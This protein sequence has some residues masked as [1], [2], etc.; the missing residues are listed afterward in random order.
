MGDSSLVGQDL[1]N[2]AAVGLE[3]VVTGTNAHK[4][5]GQFVGV[6]G[7]E[8]A[9]QAGEGQEGVGE[10]DDTGREEEAEKDAAD[11]AHE[12]VGV[13]EVE[14]Q[15][16]KASGGEGQGEYRHVSRGGGVDELAVKC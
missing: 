10:E 1:V 14:G 15:E 2:V 6:E 3:E 12:N 4:H 8:E 7:E 11:V 5:G 9:D 16:A 13:G